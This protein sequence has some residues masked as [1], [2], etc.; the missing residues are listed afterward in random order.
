MRD[1]T[2][3][4][5][6]SIEV[7]V[8]GF[9]QADYICDSNIAT[10]IYLASHLR[11]PILVE[12]PPGVGKTEL[13]IAASAYFDIPLV[14][15]Q[16]YEG[17]DESKALYEWK[18]GKQLLYTQILKEKLGDVLKGA[19]GLEQSIERLHQFGDSFFSEE[20]LDARPLLQALREENGAVLLI[21]EVDKSDQ[22]F[23][24]FLLEVL[25]DYQITIPE[26]GT[27]GGDVP[28]LV[29]L[30]SNATREMGDALRRRCLHLY[31]PFPEADRERRIVQIR[32]PDISETLRNQLVSFVQSLRHMDLKKLPAVSETIDWARTLML[33]HA[34]QL[35]PEMVRN[36]L[37]VILKFQDDVERVDTEVRA[38]VR[39]AREGR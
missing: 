29:V 26:I 8:E 6:G 25:S 3:K 35:D 9:E 27:V 23:E 17:L 7:I 13:A 32:V 18:Y 24:A 4:K 21:D 38:M 19:E 33:M 20:F 30:T 31:I 22:E 16:C 36:T 5:V 39:T 14:R 11:K 37:N 12:G 1:D 34:D 28:P 15:L 2:R 10:A